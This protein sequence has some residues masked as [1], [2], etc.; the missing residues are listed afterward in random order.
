MACIKTLLKYPINRVALCPGGMITPQGIIKQQILVITAILYTAVVFAQDENFTSDRPGLSDAPD[1]ITKKTWQL[2]TGSDISTYNHY[3]IYQLS[4]NTLKFGISNYFEAR[5]DLSLQYDP[6]MKT[7]SVQLPSV[8]L[9]T[10]LLK[11]HKAVPKTALIAEYYP[12]PLSGSQGSGFAMELCFSNGFKNGNSLYYNIGANW[13][14]LSQPPSFNFLLGY[15]YSWN[16][17]FSTFME[18]YLYDGSLQT[19]NYVA[20][21]GITYQINKRLQIDL[22]AGRDL[23]H[24]KGNYYLDGGLSFNL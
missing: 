4:Q 8:G 3:G 22:A 16:K 9:K 24:P 23:V 5:M 18:L 20:D 15:S 6:E 13:Q 17:K 11:Q 7:Y 10:L 2:A 19:V 21:I 14:Q 12:P 1:L